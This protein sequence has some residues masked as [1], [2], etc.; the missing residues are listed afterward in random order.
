MNRYI[1]LIIL[2]VLLNAA[3]QLVLKQGMR[4]IGHFAFSLKNLWPI[5]VKVALNP[6]IMT[7]LLCYAVSV[8]VWLMVLS[9]VEVPAGWAF[10]SSAWEST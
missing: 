4:T 5:S 9:R 1:P 2:G 6:F 7:G 3:A 8:V 10:S